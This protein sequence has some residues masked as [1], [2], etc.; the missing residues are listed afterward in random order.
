MPISDWQRKHPKSLWDTVRRGRKHITGKDLNYA[1]KYDFRVI[2]LTQNRAGELIFHAPIYLPGIVFRNG[3]L[4]STQTKPHNDDHADAH[5]VW[6]GLRLEK[7]E[8]VRVEARTV[9]AVWFN[10]DHQDEWEAPGEVDTDFER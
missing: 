8:K 3:T 7:G 2:W 4:F 1:F 10:L 9:T 5:N 6:K